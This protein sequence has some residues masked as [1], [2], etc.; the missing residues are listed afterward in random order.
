L[1]RTHLHARWDLFGKKFEQKFGHRTALQ[2]WARNRTRAALIAGSGPPAKSIQPGVQF[3]QKAGVTGSRTP[4]SRSGPTFVASPVLSSIS[5]ARP[6]R[7][8]G[9]S[10]G[11]NRFFGM[12]VRNRLIGSS[13]SIP[14]TEL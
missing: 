11:S 14:R 3:A 2:G 8:A 1:R 12:R 6:D 9:P 7:V 13:M 4:P 5:T 10:A